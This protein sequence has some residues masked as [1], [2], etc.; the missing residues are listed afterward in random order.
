[1]AVSRDMRASSV[2]S[3]CN[4]RSV[5]WRSVRSRMKPVKKRRSP[6]RISPTS[7]FMGKVE[8]S[9]RWPSHDPV[10]ADDPL[11]ASSKVALN[12]AVVL[13]VIGRGHQ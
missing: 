7:S 10:D 4:C 1:M 2:C 9:L 6:D 12:V 13:V 8:P 3:S 5:S 11:L